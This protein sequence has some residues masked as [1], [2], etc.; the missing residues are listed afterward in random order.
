MTCQVYSDEV[1][2]PVAAETDDGRMTLRAREAESESITVAVWPVHGRERV[3][4]DAGLLAERIRHA[5]CTH[6]PSFMTKL[7][8]L[9][10][11]L[12]FSHFH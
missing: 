5:V 9:L 7:N 3:V 6:Q 10:H 12:F 2:A 4:Q 1:V 8:R 11:P